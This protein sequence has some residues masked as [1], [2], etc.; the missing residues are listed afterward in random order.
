MIPGLSSGSP[1]T[2]PPPTRRRKTGEIDVIVRLTLLTHFG[3]LDVRHSFG[4]QGPDGDSQL[5]RRQE[6]TNVEIIQV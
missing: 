4:A 2:S 1:G 5:R 3:I 6:E